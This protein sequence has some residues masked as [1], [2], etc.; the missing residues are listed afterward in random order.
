M[1]IIPVVIAA[2]SSACP[3]AGDDGSLPG[4]PCDG[5]A[6]SATSA[7]EDLGGCLTLVETTAS[8]VAL[9]FGDEFTIELELFGDPPALPETWGDANSTTF[10]TITQG[11]LE[12]RI[13]DGSFDG[14]APVGEG[15][16]AITSRDGDTLHGTFSGLAISTSADALVE[17]LVVE[18]SF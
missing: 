3:V 9:Q 8:S 16:S 14:G 13:A 18:A 15:E 11:D 2:A 12:W 1:F 10:V 4:D 7:S 6:V 17:G 5:A